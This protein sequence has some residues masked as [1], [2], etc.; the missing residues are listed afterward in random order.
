MCICKYIHIRRQGGISSGEILSS[1]QARNILCKFRGPAVEF[2]LDHGETRLLAKRDPTMRDD[3][4]F[5][6]PLYQYNSNIIPIVPVVS[7]FFSVIP[8]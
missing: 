6:F 4:D 5:S 3:R 2:T 1:M 8:I 7:I